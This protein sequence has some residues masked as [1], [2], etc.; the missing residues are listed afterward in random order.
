MDQKI[1]PFHLIIF[2]EGGLQVPGH[3]QAM[4]FYGEFDDGLH[5]GIAMLP[6]LQHRELKYPCKCHV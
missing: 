2:L 1:L 4:L 6:L 5:G 3:R